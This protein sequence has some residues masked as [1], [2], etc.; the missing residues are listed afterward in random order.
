MA[1]EFPTLKNDLLLRAARG[2]Q[3]ERAPVWVMRQAGRYLPEFRKTR[4]THEFFEICRSPTLAT[5]ITMQPIRRYAGLLDAAIIFSDILVVPQAMGMELPREVDVEKELGYVFEALTLTRKTLAGQVPL[6]G[7]SG[8]PWTLMMYMIEGGGSQTPSKQLLERTTDICVQYLIGQVNAGAQLLQV[9]DSNAGDLSPHD[10]STFSLP[11]LK[12]I[13][14]EV[15][16]GLKARQLP[17]V[18]LTL[19]AKGASPSLAASAGYDTI[20]L[21]WTLDPRDVAK[22]TDGI[23]DGRTI[24]LQGN[25]DPVVLYGGRDAIEREV[26]RMCNM[27]HDY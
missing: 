15:R 8:A 2:E 12:R 11:Y 18:P 26:K 23:I 19:F 14:D 5:E 25:L 9:F 27:F 13:A 7:F 22:L 17:V 6:I 10:F 21:D 3:T 24:T 4:E 16:E 20:G 1:Q